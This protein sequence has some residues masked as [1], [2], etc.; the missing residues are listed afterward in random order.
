LFL[1]AVEA[2]FRTSPI[3]LIKMSGCKKAEFS[4]DF[5]QISHTSRDRWF[6]ENW[7]RNRLF[8]IS[9]NRKL[10]TAGKYWGTVKGIGT[11]ESSHASRSQVR[12]TYVLVHVTSETLGTRT[13]MCTDECASRALPSVSRIRAP[14][15]DEE[16]RDQ[17]D[18]KILKYILRNLDLL[19]LQIKDS[20]IYV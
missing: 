18:S 9:W 1:Y 17:I 2:F 16:T 20:S 8:S 6:E 7:N 15:Y 11:I 5:V 3:G 19:S 12:N 14:K 10:E 4:N 13:S